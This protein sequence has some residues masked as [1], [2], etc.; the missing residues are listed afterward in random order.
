[1]TSVPIPAKIF[2]VTPGTPTR[3]RPGNTPRKPHARGTRGAR[4]PSSCSS[5]P[6]PHQTA[7]MVASPH[8]NIQRLIY[9]R[10][11]PIW[12]WVMF[13][14]CNERATLQTGERQSVYP[15]PLF[16]GPFANSTLHCPKKA[17]SQIVPTFSSTASPSCSRLIVAKIRTNISRAWPNPVLFP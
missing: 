7:A 11:P 1:M 9:F 8:R 15:S 6:V 4:P 13:C 10:Q 3:W 12:L 14:W 2:S 16:L 17:P 5:H